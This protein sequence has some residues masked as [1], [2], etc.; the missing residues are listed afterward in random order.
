MPT[1]HCQIFCLIARV[2]CSPLSVVNIKDNI[3]DIVNVVVVFQGRLS[4]NS[5]ALFYKRALFKAQ[6]W[7]VLEFVLK[8]IKNSQQGQCLMFLGWIFSIRLCSNLV[9]HSQYSKSCKLRCCKALQYL[10]NHLQ[11]HPLKFTVHDK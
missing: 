4:Y 11:Y 2:C 1:Y 3:I 6:G 8:M 10:L 7:H 5:F 9:Y